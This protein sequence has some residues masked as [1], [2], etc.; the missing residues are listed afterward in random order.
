MANPAD[1]AEFEFEAEGGKT[2]YIWVRGANLDG[3]NLSDAFWMQFDQEIGTAKLGATYNHPKAFGNWLDAFPAKTYAW[4]SAL[5]A[6]A[7]QTIRFEKSGRHKLTIHPRHGGHHLDQIW[8]SATQ[9]KRPEDNWRRTASAGEIVIDA[10][11]ATRVVGKFKVEE[12]VSGG[13]KVLRVDGGLTT[14]PFVV[15]PPHTDRGRKTK[16]SSEF[17]LK[18]DPKNLGV[19]LRRKLDYAYPNQRAEVFV[20]P[21]DIAEPSEA[22]FKSAGIW[23]LAG[24]NMC[25]YSDPRGELGATLHI[26]QTSNR[27]FRDDEFIVS[28]DLTE[29]RSSIRVRVKFIP[30]TV[31]LFP[32][33]PLGELA[34]SEIR[35]DAYC[36]LLGE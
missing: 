35:Y 1:Y 20:A 18:L 25:V 29:G 30:V 36:Y 11:E 22:D 13:G 14:E 6:E 24:S 3:N 23:Y 34:W 19:L 27:R 7:P 10:A 12:A 16:T 4:S 15:Y 33:H 8:L 9:A 2:Y 32:E 17:V 26:V 21:G 31:P 28:R 5:P